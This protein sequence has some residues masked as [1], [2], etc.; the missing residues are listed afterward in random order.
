MHILVEPLDG[1]SAQEL[2]AELD[3][4]LH[5]RYG[6]GEPVQAHAGEF[7]APTGRFLVA[8]A[9]GAPIACAGVRYLEPG[10]AE[11]KRMYVRERARR[12]GI[13]KTLLRACEQVA[14]DLG[15]ERLWLETGLAQPE[16]I[17]L[18]ESAGYRPVR[19]FGQ[20]KDSQSSRYYG[21]DLPREAPP[22]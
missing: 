15:Y 20:Y 4:D 6:G 17:A 11:L 9:D 12:R 22:E 1:P 7:S 19:R 3:A 10:T 13:A 14:R 5:R 16:A 8:Y 21:I 2:L 18:Y